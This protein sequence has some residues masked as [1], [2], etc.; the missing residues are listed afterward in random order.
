MN[1]IFR[2]FQ[3]KKSISH[4]EE[5]ESGI[6]FPEIQSKNILSTEEYK[7]R[8]MIIKELRS[9]VKHIYDNDEYSGKIV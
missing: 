9:N 1:F 7:K 2:L 8:R 6:G 4:I 5:N 3:R